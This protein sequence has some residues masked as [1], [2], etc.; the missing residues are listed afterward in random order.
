MSRGTLKAT[1]LKGALVL[2]PLVTIFYIASFAAD[3]WLVRQS[4]GVIYSDVAKLPQTAVAIVLGGGVHPGGIL[5]KSSRWR[6]KS[7][8]MLYKQGKVSTLLITGDGGGNVEDEL[9]PMTQYALDYGVPIAAIWQDRYGY[10]TLTS[11][12]NAHEKF[13]LDRAVIVTQMY[14][15]PRAIYLARS[16]GMHPIGFAAED[17]GDAFL[18][19]KNRLHGY[20]ASLLAVLQTR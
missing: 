3:S 20:P 18:R 9:T 5:S 19:F 8:V 6:M 4:R 17:H 11:C 14:H 2:V 7:A 16:V 10:R 12:E 13:H 1:V 15:L